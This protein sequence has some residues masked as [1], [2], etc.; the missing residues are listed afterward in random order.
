MTTKTID[1]HIGMDRAID[2]K[3]FKLLPIIFRIFLRVR[4][5]WPLFSS[6]KKGPAF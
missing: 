4:A 5:N 6:M 1:I 3:A 2:K